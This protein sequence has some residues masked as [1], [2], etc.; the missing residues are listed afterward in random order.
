M[1]P[2]GAVLPCGCNGGRP[3]PGLVALSAR[4]PNQ[5][6]PDSSRRGCPLLPLSAAPPHGPGK[7]SCARWHHPAPCGSARGPTVH[8]LPAWAAGTLLPHPGAVGPREQ[9]PRGS[10]GLPGSHH[11]G[12]AHPACRVR[13][14]LGWIMGT[15]PAGVSCGVTGCSGLLGL[16]WDR[17]PGAEDTHGLALLSHGVPQHH[18][19]VTVA[20]S[21]QGGKVA[22]GCCHDE[23][24][25]SRGAGSCGCP[26]SPRL[27]QCPQSSFPQEGTEG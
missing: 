12:N 6:R 5:R 14:A 11:P 10:A 26:Q 8:L 19:G 9:S 7:P 13:S 25:V 18:W 27:R 17:A 22:P 4:A 24:G 15:V 23:F 2:R 20:P 21:L 3:W 16:C 1:S